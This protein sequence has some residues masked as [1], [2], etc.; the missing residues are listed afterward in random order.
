MP[1]L[2]AA[3]ETRFIDEV[4]LRCAQSAEP[5]VL[6]S[7]QLEPD[8]VASALVAWDASAAGAGS[9]WFDEADAV[10]VLETLWPFDTVT[11]RLAIDAPNPT[12]E[13]QYS[14]G[15]RSACG[16]QVFASSD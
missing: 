16:V 13:L 15:G 7:L 5:L 2:R 10:Y 4:V 1:A 8:G 6:H 3:A 12:A 14:S 9:G 11:I